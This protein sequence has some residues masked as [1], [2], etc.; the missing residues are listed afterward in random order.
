MVSIRT[1]GA[2]AV[3]YPFGYSEAASLDDAFR[4]IKAFLYISVVGKNGPPVAAKGYR[5]NTI[6]FPYECTISTSDLL[7]P[8]NM[9]QV[10]VE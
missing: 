7:F 5:L 2:N 6:K 1:D 10:C 9:A 4:D 3:D 8:Y